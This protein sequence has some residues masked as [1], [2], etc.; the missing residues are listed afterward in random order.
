MFIPSNLAKVV[1]YLFALPNREPISHDN[2]NQLDPAIA[3]SSNLGKRANSL[4]IGDIFSMEKSST[5]DAKAPT[6]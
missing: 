5:S 6:I 4:H 2:G 1:F 3:D